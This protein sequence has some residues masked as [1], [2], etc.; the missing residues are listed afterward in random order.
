M[1]LLYDCH[2]HI[3]MDG[4]SFREAADRHKNGPDEGAVRSALKALQGEGVVYFRDGGD[5]F[6]A[7]LFARE[8][9][10]E[11]GIEYATCAFAIHKKGH[12]GGIVGFEWSDMN[13]YRALV[14]KAKSLGAQFIKLM[15]SGLIDFGCYGEIT[16]AALEREEIKELVNIAH[17]E[18]FA[19]MAHVNG[20]RAVLDA[21]ECGTDSI[22][23]GCYAD[24]ACFEAMKQHG[25]IWVPTLAAIRGFCG[26]AGYEGGVP[27][28]IL[29]TQLESVSRASEAG[30]KI[31][32]GSDSG[33]F[34]VP[35]GEG[36]ACEMRLLSQ[37]GVPKAH[38]E[39]ANNQLRQKFTVPG[40]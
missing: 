11:Y 8:I 13:E 38:I 29:E 34:G 32:C 21:A 39:A 14:K 9:A 22:E 31:A 10:P 27:E 18:G 28:R 36:T 7:G 12:Y 5:P 16:G 3:F 25:T 17:G 23:H 35:H 20:A 19:V 15:Y 4:R 40:I 33:A 37:A 2:G 1:A 24:T 26:R 30:V 6:G